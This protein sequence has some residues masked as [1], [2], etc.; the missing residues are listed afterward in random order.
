[1][2]LQLKDEQEEGN[3]SEFASNYVDVPDS[4][5]AFTSVDQLVDL[6]E[7][8]AAQETAVPEVLKNVDWALLKKQKQG[9]LETITEMEEKNAEYYKY[10]IEDLTG[11]LHFLDTIQDYVVDT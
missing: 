2:Y 7:C 6:I 8:S 3:G 10:S 5:S 11:I 4:L 1:M 9:L